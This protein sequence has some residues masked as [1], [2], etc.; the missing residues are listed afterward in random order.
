MHIPFV[1]MDPMVEGGSSHYVFPCFKVVLN[2]TL[3]GLKV[4]LTMEKTTIL[5]MYL[6]LKLVFFIIFPLPCYFSV[7]FSFINTADKF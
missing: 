2:I 6:V 3:M 1:P 5:K 7:G 4:T